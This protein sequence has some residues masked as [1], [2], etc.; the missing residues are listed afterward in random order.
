MILVIPLGVLSVGT[1]INVV[2]AAARAAE[3]RRRRLPGR[4]VV[5]ARRRLAE[6]VRQVP[7]ALQPRHRVRGGRPA[8]RGGPRTADRTGCRPEPRG[9]LLPARQP[10]A[11]ATCVSA[12]A[13]STRATGRARSTRTAPRR[14]SGGSSPTTSA[15]RTRTST[16]PPTRARDEAEQGEAGRSR[17]SRRRSRSDP[18]DAA[19]AGSVVDARRPDRRSTPTPDPSASA[20]AGPVRIADPSADAEPGPDG[21]A[22]RHRPPAQSGEPS[23]SP[24]PGESRRAVVPRRRPGEPG[25]AVTRPGETAARR[26]GGEPTSEALG[27]KLD[28]LI[29]QGEAADRERENG[30]PKHG[31]ADKPW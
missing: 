28:E 16:R 26:S 11:H 3:L 13:T 5:G 14:R 29:A 18:A 27:D 9:G 1:G 23:S 24:T 25:D 20:D 30:G 10:R 7:A 31:L 17:S 21:R 6:P 4:R 19:V 8:A 2:L 15:T 22:V 12:T